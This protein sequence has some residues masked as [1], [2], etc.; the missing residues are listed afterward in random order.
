ML[1]KLAN[2][3]VSNVFLKSLGIRRSKNAPL[4]IDTIDKSMLVQKEITKSKK[5]N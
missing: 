2:F 1:K 4:P 5:A 3:K